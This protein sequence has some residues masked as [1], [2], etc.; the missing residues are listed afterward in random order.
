MINAMVLLKKEGR[1]KA[2][3]Y[4]TDWLT[5]VIGKILESI[6][7]DVIGGHLESHGHQ[8][9]NSNKS[10]EVTNTECCGGRAI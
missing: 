7:K 3:N 4:R 8:A 2:G 6:I 9:V 1:Q 5:S 10:L